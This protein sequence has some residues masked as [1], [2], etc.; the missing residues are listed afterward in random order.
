VENSKSAQML[1]TSSN[2]LGLCFIVLTSLKVLKLRQ[3]TLI[4]EFSAV[5]TICFMTSSILS[6]LA[7]RSR[8]DKNSTRYENV[9]EFFFMSGLSILFITTMVITFDI[10]K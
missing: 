3:S 5:A 9:A 10:I 6:F 8:S 1:N 4:D 7:I 2:L